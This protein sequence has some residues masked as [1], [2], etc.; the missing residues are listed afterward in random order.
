[1]SYDKKF[2]EIVLS[3][4]DAGESKTKVRVM[5]K[6]GKNTINQREKLRAETGTLENRELDRKPRKIE[7][8]LLRADVQEYPDDFDKERA[9]HFGVSRSGLRYARVRLKITRKKDNKLYRTQRRRTS[10]VY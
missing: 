6:L 9:K 3:Y 5:F 2:R 4:V 1:M 8:E 7:A 10:G